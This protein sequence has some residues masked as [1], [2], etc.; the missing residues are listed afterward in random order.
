MKFSEEAKL[1]ERIHQLVRLKATGRP[2]QPARRLGIS[3]RSLS[4]ILNEMREDGFPIAYDRKR[5]RYYYETEV[6][7]EVK[8]YVAQEVETRKVVG[9]KFFK[10]FDNFF[11]SA[12]DSGAGRSFLCGR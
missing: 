10:F 12:P 5:E 9:G 8:F 2:K 3:K 11:G 7:F 6:V 1:R 4:R